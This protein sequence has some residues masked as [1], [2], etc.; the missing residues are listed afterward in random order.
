[1]LRWSGRKWQRWLQRFGLVSVWFHLRVEGGLQRM[2]ARTVGSELQKHQ[3]GAGMGGGGGG[4]H[5]RRS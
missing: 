5:M 3:A 4:L 1:M 2:S